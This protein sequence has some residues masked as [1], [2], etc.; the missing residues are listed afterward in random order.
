MREQ[1]SKQMGA[2]VVSGLVPRPDLGLEALVGQ[3]S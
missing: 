2:L 1:M 3:C